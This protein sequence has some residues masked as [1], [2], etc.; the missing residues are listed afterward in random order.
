MNL[1]EVMCYLLKFDFIKFYSY[2]FFNHE[3]GNTGFI[4][5]IGNDLPDYAASQPR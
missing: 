2:T 5:N 3:E 1:H 4:R